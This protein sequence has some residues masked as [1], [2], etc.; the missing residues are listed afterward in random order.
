MTNL[1][2]SWDRKD[3][4]CIAVLENAWVVYDEAGEVAFW[5][6]TVEGTA[7]ESLPH[8]FDPFRKGSAG[9]SRSHE[10]GGLGLSIA[11]QLAELMDGTSRR[12]VRP[13]ATP[14]LRRPA[15][16]PSRTV[17]KLVYYCRVSFRT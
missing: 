12:P 11:E 9:V 5:E 17:R 1:E 6:G 16:S 14:P 8:L 10:G 4:S 2:T 13:K 7:P 15:F 3:G